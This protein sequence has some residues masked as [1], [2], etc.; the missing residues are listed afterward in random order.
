MK[1]FLVDDHELIRCGVREALVHHGHEIVGEAGCAGHGVKR[2]AVLQLDAAVVDIRMPD[3]SGLEVVR[4]VRDRHPFAGIVVLTMFPTDDVLF[5]AL[6]AGAN[7]LVGKDASLSAIVTAVE[8]AAG[9][10][11]SFTAKDLTAAMRRRMHP[12]GPLLTPREYEVLSLMADGLSVA[13]IARRLS[14]SESTAKTH[15]AKIYQKLDAGNRA[16]AVM[17]AVRR[18]ILSPSAEAS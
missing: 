15:A 5:D 2:S 1:V 14:V 17:A 9:D 8:N 12:V 4:A 16:Q 3:G 7:A 18:G 10:P 6:D 11:T 13:Q